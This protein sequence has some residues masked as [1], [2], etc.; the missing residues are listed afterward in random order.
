M[1]TF[2]AIYSFL[3]HHRHRVPQIF[4]L[5]VRPSRRFL[6]YI[7]FLYK[8]HP[9][10]TITVIDVQQKQSTIAKLKTTHHLTY[11]TYFRY[12]IDHFLPDHLDT[13]LYLDSDILVTQPL[14]D[15]FETD[16]TNALLAA[17]PEVDS[18]D[19]VKRL[20]L[21]PAPG[22]FNAGV[23]L[24]NLCRWRTLRIG[25]RLIDFAK[26]NPSLIRWPSQDP[27]NIVTSQQWI[28]L[29]PRF[30]W[31]HGYAQLAGPVHPKTQPAIIHYSGSSKPWQLS[32]STAYQ[33]LFWKHLWATPYRWFK[34]D[35]IIIA[36]L[37]RARRTVRRF[38]RPSQ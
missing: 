31:N 15:L 21:P 4:V 27:L 13:V 6:R 9:S 22:Y 23:L 38:V 19:D 28:P 14:D 2:V 18:F 34:P 36:L 35:D 37:R 3:L 24:I 5:C 29:E 30:N 16:L 25:S 20:A 32:S 17:V 1:P 7:P 26:K 12:F 33:L 11:G 8:T 10:A